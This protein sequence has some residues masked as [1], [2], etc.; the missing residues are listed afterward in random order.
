MHTAASDP[1]Q[2]RQRIL[3]T[4][5]EVFAEQGF[6]GSTVRDI[7]QRAGANV[8]AVNY[9]FG[10]KEALYLE[11]LRFAHTCAFTKYPPDLGLKPGATPRQRLHAF[12]RSFLFRVLDDGRPAWHGKLMAREIADPT[13]ALESIVKDGIRPHFATLRG[14]VTDLLGPKLAADPER[15]RYAAWSIVGQC[16][17]YFY[18]RPVI[19]QLHPG[20]GLKPDDLEAIAGHITD[21]SL[22]GLKHYPKPSGGAAS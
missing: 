1:L 12:V 4:A 6:R 2:T 3:E 20:Q 19:L 7:C 8:A 10:D 13:G 16:L 11:V 18:G 22:A 5:G 21:F 14:I 9:H 15:V 17:F